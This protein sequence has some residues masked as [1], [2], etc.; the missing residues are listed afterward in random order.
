MFIKQ[1]DSDIDVAQ[2]YVDDIVFG[3]TS[4]NCM[5]EFVNQM[6]QEFEI[7]IV[8]ELTYFLG[9]QVKQLK[10]KIFISQSKYVKDLVKKFGL[11]TTKHM[12]TSMGINV[13]LIKNENGFSIDPR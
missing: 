10:D 2:I 8:S 4:H 11:E 12:R 3:S 1:I 7:S 9:F 6:K 13:K 5:Q